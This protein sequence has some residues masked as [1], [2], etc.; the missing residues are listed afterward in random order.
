MAAAHTAFVAST[1][2]PP[3]ACGPA[4]RRGP[5]SRSTA[6]RSPSCGSPTAPSACSWRS[7]PSPT[8][9]SSRSTPGL[10]HH[11]TYTGFG[12]VH[13]ADD[14]GHLRTRR[15]DRRVGG[16]AWRWAGTT[17]LRSWCSSSAF[18]WLELIEVT[19]Y[20]NHYWFVTLF[21]LV[22]LTLPAATQLVAS[23]RAERP[24]R[25][26]IDPPRRGGARPRPGCGGL[27]VRRARQAQRRLAPARAAVALVAPESQPISRSSARGSTKCGSRSR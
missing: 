19:T 23:T 12:W 21:G 27:C 3:A 9:G 13:A 10:S 1:A 16:D 25:I 11:F 7:G 5:A 18:V 6:H 22:L 20:L 15:R 4:R 14:L 17:D 24:Q 2:R 8:A 26:G